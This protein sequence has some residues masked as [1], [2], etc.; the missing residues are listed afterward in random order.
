MKTIALC[1]DE[2]LLDLNLMKFKFDEHFGD[3]NTLLS[4]K[5][6]LNELGEQLNFVEKC[7]QMNS[8]VLAALDFVAKENGVYLISYEKEN[9]LTWMAQ[10][11]LRKDVVNKMYQLE[12]EG[13]QFEIVT[14]KSRE[15][16]KTKFSNAGAESFIENVINPND[17]SDTVFEQS[18]YNLNA[19]IATNATYEILDRKIAS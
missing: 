13:Y 2:N 12:T 8:L 14:S 5:K 10:L 9:F 19:L 17:L 4:W 15:S 16:L 6:K 18:K 1:L 3:T 11:P 7:N